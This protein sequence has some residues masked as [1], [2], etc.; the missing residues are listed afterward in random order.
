MTSHDL[1]AAHATG[2][3]LFISQFGVHPPLSLA[4]LFRDHL[5]LL[6][7]RPAHWTSKP[8]T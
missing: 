3:N 6:G 2:L 1:C 4:A 7:T 8:V 5:R